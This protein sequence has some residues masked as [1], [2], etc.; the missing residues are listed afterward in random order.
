MSGQ[1]AVIVSAHASPSSSRGAAPTRLRGVAYSYFQL[2]TR[3]SVSSHVILRSRRCLSQLKKNHKFLQLTNQICWC[4]FLL[5]EGPLKLFCKITHTHTH[6]STYKH[7]L[8]KSF[9]SAISN[10]SVCIPVA[11][12]NPLQLSKS[13]SPSRQSSG[14]QCWT[15]WH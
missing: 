3:R 5:T 4:A 7:P 1:R 14:C 10:L 2:W 13:R 12:Y 9:L 6:R 15:G 11:G 8:T